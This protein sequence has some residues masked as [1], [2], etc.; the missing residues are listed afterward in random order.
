VKTLWRILA[1]LAVIGA[2]PVQAGVIFS[3]GN[4]PQTDENVLFHDS[5]A[6]CVDGPALMVV[7]HTQ[8]SNVLA[9]LTSDVPIMA[10]GPG[11]NTVGTD[12]GFSWMLFTIPGYTFQTM[13]LQLTELSTAGDGSVIFTAHTVA[14]G[15]LTSA[16]LFE[17]HTGGNYYTVTVTATGGTLITGLE[18]ST[19][20]PQHDVSQIRVGAVAAEIPEPATMLLTGAVLMGLGLMRRRNRQ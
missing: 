11:H 16:A 14:D 19:A 20:Q 17:G 2:A 4:N 18:F 12:T 15:D 1:A 8:N 10:V 3:L 5:C 13:I 6:G 7:G 9:D